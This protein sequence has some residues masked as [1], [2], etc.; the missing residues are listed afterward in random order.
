MNLAPAKTAS[1][2]EF[3]VEMHQARVI[4]KKKRMNCMKTTGELS[5][6]TS[7]VPVFKG[8]SFDPAHLDGVRQESCR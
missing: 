6:L 5:V 3:S 1:C 8:G 2:L 7:S 4:V